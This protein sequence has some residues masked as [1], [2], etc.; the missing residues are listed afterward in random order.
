MD[1][2]AELDRIAEV[3]GPES[4]PVQPQLPTAVMQVLDVHAADVRWPDHSTSPGV[5]RLPFLPW[6]FSRPAA[7]S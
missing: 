1:G 2:L 6:I 5:Y 7:S 4:P 3:L